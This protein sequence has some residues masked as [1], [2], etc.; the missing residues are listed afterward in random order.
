MEVTPT[1]GA[2][3]AV[4]HLEW[5][6]IAIWDLR[7]STA[8]WVWIPF[9]RATSQAPSAETQ[10]P[11][12]IHSYNGSQPPSQG[13]DFRDMPY[14]SYSSGTVG[15]A[16]SFSGTSYEPSQRSLSAVTGADGKPIG[17]GIDG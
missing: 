3:W 11:G 17:L 10:Q 15:T 6:V 2:T 14:G 4:F 13:P 1:S 5:S 8:T 7:L 12:S 16:G 9:S